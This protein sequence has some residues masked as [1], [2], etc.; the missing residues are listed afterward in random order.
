MG[1]IRVNRPRTAALLL[2]L[3][4]LGVCKVD[5]GP[6]GSPAVDV[7]GTV[8][9]A[10]AVFMAGPHAVSLSIGVRQAGGARTY[11]FGTAS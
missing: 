3:P 11:H 7:D 10:A 6:G 2:S 9:R 5:C 1:N 4:L 8:A